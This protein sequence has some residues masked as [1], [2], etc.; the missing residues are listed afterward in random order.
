VIAEDPESGERRHE[1]DVRYITHEPVDV[2]RDMNL[3]AFHQRDWVVVR[4][5]VNKYTL[6]ETYPEYREEI[7]N[8]QTNLTQENHYLGGQFMDRE[9]QSDT[10]PI[11]TFYHSRTNACPDG[12]QMDMLTDG[13]VLSDSILL[14]EKIPV[15]R[16]A[17]GNQIGTPMGMSV[18]VDLMPLQEMIDAHFT[19]IL[20]INENFG[21]PK[22]LLPI[23]SEINSDNVSAGFQ[24]ISYNPTSGA[25]SVLNMP[26]VPDTL[27]NTMVQLQHEM[28]TLSGVNS[29]S[30]GNPEASLKSG[31]ALALVQSMA[32][33]F[34]QPL[35][36]SYVALLEDVGTAT[37]QILKEYADAPRIIQIAG[38]RNRGIIQQEFTG[39]DVDS[40][41]RVQVQVGNPL[42]KTVSGRLAIAQDLLQ[43]K[44]ITTYQEY[45]MV[46]ETGEIEPLTQGA[47]SELLNL[48]SENELLLE[49]QPV[50][51][52]FTDNHVLH[53]QEHT[54]LASDPV[55]RSDPKLFGIISEHIMQH[56]SQLSDPMYQN[57]R[58]L[59]G[60]PSM[61]PM[62]APG[63]M[64]AQAQAP[65]PAATTMS[66]AGGPGNVVT[67]QAPMGNQQIQ[68][69]AASVKMPNSPQ[70]PL[71][72]QRAQLPG[73]QA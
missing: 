66:A 58:M 52:L 8:Q 67:P 69:K 70:N 28:E 40:I 11:L 5:Y 50:P 45:L 37:I 72:G 41:S 10:I 53:I 68:Q 1:G 2:V 48:S 32:I 73:G 24:A 31:S 39:S 14:Y 26:V 49:G 61:P 51:V 62:T 42:S 4:N 64:P 27:F 7:V 29:V 54:S 38:K 18:S 43:N 36:N 60:Q 33:Q 44:I 34:N 65:Q 63:A 17:P 21:I 22:I 46:L 23:G 55:V 57:Y 47:T 16:I 25:P 71:T 19:A 20:S 59:M 13:T 3:K 9:S 35:Q 6:A 15:H 30:R 12:R 56:I